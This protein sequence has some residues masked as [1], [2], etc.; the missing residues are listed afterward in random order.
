MAYLIDGNNLLGRIAPHELRERTGRDGLV[1][2]LLAFQRV[3]RARIHLVFDGNP[4]ATPT[5][6]PVNA[7][8]TVH[9][10]GEGQSADD[11]IRDMI[12]RQTD[13]R[14]F[15]VVS[16][17]RAIRELAKKR[18]PR[19]RDLRR[20][21]PR[22]QGGDQGGEEAARA[23]QEDGS[24]VLAR[25]RSLGRGLQVQAM[26][27]LLASSARD[28]WG[29]SLAAALARR[30]WTPEL[31]VDT[32]ARAAR[33]GRRVDRRRAARRSP[34][35]AT[36][37]LGDVVAHRRARRRRSP[38][39]PPAWP[40]SGVRWAGRTVLHT[41]GLL[42]ARRSRSAGPARG[43]RRLAPPGPVLSPARTPR[44][45]SSPASPGVSKATRPPSQT[46]GRIVRALRGRR[47]SSGG[48][49]QAPLPRRLQPGFERARRPGMRRRPGCSGGRDRSREADAMLLPLVQGT[50]QN[51]KDLGLEKALTGTDPQGGCRHGQGAPGSPR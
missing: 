2:R 48:E 35:R 12:A 20:L 8:F 10:P 7:K 30:G 27:K 19:V 38:G 25:D 33:D 34:V 39:P 3:T 36:S 18:G 49:G 47:P 6:V 44:P 23:R 24:P 41:S 43:P 31:I 45:R 13:K 9:Y 40:R 5:D 17:D 28:G 50:L 4:E 22:A 11:V 21:R 16:S 46:C 42:P 32:D 1:V 15:F 29:R 51:V 14:R 37:R 26:K